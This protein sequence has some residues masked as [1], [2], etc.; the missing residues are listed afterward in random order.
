MRFQA[1]H[2]VLPHPSETESGDAVVVR[3]E[4]ERAVFAVVDG[5][6]HGPLAALA[7][8]RAVRAVEASFGEPDVG[9]IMLSIHAALVGTRGA[10]ATVLT[11]DGDIVRASGVGNVALRS[12]R[13]DLPFVLSP[14]ILG[15][16]VRKY[17]ATESRLRDG[18]RIV[19][20]SD[21]IASDLGLDAISR[22]SADE[23]ADSIVRTHR[24]TTDDAAVLVLDVRS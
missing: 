5:L 9:R 7:A 14:G 4:G 18:Q 1:A 11:V 20:H 12:H 16:Q 17:R 24:K 22:L 15:I 19:L 23:A 2:R 13:S 6:G 3:V 10:A 8:A 21:G